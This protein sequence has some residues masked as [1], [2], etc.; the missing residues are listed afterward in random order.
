MDVSTIIAAV[1]LAT[2]WFG[3]PWW[4]WLICIVVIAVLGVVILPGDFLE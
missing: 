3:Y 1:Q 4:A 2:E